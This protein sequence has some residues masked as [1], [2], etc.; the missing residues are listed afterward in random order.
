MLT[1]VRD[2]VVGEKLKL[3]HTDS[4]PADLNGFIN[5]F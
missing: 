1:R 2:S 4:A 5:T 3:A